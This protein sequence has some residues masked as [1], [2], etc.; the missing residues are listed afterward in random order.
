MERLRHGARLA[1]EMNLPILVS[2]GAPDRTKANELSEAQV[3]AKVL[4]DELGI[5]VRWIEDQ[6]N[7]TEENLKNSLG[8]LEKDQIKKIYLATH[9]WHMPRVLQTVIQIQRKQATTVT[10]KDSSG[11]GFDMEVVPA[12]HGYYQK[13]NYTPLDFYPSS[14]GFQRT[15][16]IF[17][18][19][20][21]SLQ[22]VIKY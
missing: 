18:E 17:H 1:R 6:S 2:G 7:T 9:F 13:Q 14:E 19:L 10:K 15:R 8:I 22:C 12:P 21:D 16:W 11:N 5:Q 20:M 3:M 4:Q